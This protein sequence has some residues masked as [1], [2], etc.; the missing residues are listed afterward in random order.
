L[1]KEVIIELFGKFE[2]ACY[3][4]NG[5]ECWSARELQEILGYSKWVNFLNVINKAKKACENAGSSVSD[6]FADVGKMIAIAKGAQREIE[7]IALTRYACYLIAQNGDP[8]KPPI[9]FAQTY[10]AVQTR[11]QEIIE[12]RLLDVDRVT[13]REKLTKSEKTLSGILYERGVDSAGFAM[14][15]SKGDQ[16]LFGGFSTNDMK[17]KLGVPASK[18]LAD[19]LPAITIKAKEFANELTSHNVIEKDLNKQIQISQ[20]H[21]DNNKAVRD[22][23]LQRGVRP[24]AL[25]PAEDVKKLERRLDSDEKKA[26]KG[27]K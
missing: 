20:E 17:K 3:N 12:Q 15:R 27:S 9:A 25:P 4:Y 1:K 13:A 26:A 10:F 22:I 6:H 5:I 16:A 2:Q 24:E 8:A 23:L 7:D 19:F 14:I 18:P 21:V 11:K